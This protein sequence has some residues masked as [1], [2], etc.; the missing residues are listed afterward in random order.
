MN[1]HRCHAHACP[2]NVPPKL[3]FCRLHWGML[4]AALQREI[5]WTYVSNQEVTKDPSLE[6]M[7][8]HHRSVAFVARREGHV[9]ASVEHE[10]LAA[11][12]QRRVVVES[13]E[14]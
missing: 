6:Y 5:W 14:E 10:A 12:H 3:L 2:R 8:A 11:A 7:V 9:A 13:I 1:K 4:C